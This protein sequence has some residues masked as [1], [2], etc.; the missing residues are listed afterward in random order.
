MLCDVCRKIG[1]AVD[2]K[3]EPITNCEMMPHHLTW[4][5]LRRS[6][7][8]GCYVCNQVWESLD[9]DKQQ[10]IS[11]SAEWTCN[12]DSPPTDLISHGTYS[13]HDQS[14]VTYA[15]WF[16]YSDS[17]HLELHVRICR[18]SDFEET[19]CVLA[20][21]PVEEIS[22]ANVTP[23]LSD[24]TRSTATLSLARG[25]V[26]DCMTNHSACKKAGGAKSWYPSRL[27]DCST[28][29]GPEAYCRLIETLDADIQGP[30]MTLSHCWGDADCLKLTT[31]NHAQM[32][33][34]M[35]LP[36]LPQLYQDAV[37][38]TRTFGVRYLWIDSLCIVQEGDQLKDWFQQV[39]IMDQIY[40]NSLCNISAA[41]AP[42]GH[43]TMF[44]SRR[45]E[46]V[47]PPTSILNVD[48]V[49][50]SYLI[51]AN[52]IWH[53]QVSQALIN[54]RGWVL[55]ERLLSPRVL[56]FGDSQVLWECNE[57]AAAE[58]YPEKLP[59]TDDIDTASP[60]SLPTS[61]SE[62]AAWDSI[63]FAYSRCQLSFPHDKFTALSAVAKHMRLR[64][65]DE[66]VVGMWRRTLGYELLWKTLPS[67]YVNTRP[68]EYRAPSWSWT[69]LDGFV[70]PGWVPNP[71]PITSP[72]NIM[73][74]EIQYVTD[75]NTGPVRS[76]SMRLLGALRK[77]MLVCKHDESVQSSY[78]N[79]ELCI[80][81]GQ[82]E[83][84]SEA[85]RVLLDPP[86]RDSEWQDTPPTTLYCVRASRETDLNFNTLLFEVVDR[87]KG[88]YRRAGV[89]RIQK[90]EVW[91]L[92][93]C[94]EDDGSL[95]P[96]EEYKDG[97]YL[98]KVI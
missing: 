9:I 35:P 98:I 11:N 19:E 68:D 37:L 83:I 28:S 61:D 33:R 8:L 39:K 25:W 91:E 97:K 59:F 78:K 20:V 79:R 54:T 96:C 30:Y 15:L 16:F 64:R 63:V 60:K 41:N 72:F 1:L 46:L 50:G 93:Q 43:C 29:D 36:N 22:P 80:R 75:D 56:Y 12:G 40:L 51:E 14:D 31:E 82:S 6:N 84:L 90:E 26:R 4:S 58:I 18:V 23:E 92:Q 73:D 70:Y 89:A 13:D 3:A 76:G 38:V 95:F 66:Y 5:T 74:L 32:K 87:E 88:V 71:P 85:S 65:R 47:C 67:E 27:L 52:T 48:G 55:Q 17:R 7:F 86:Q 34:F 45:P 53:T 2:G 21:R 10:C 57:K 69:S 42:N 62:V 81:G 49:V 94:R 24:N 44:S 77:V